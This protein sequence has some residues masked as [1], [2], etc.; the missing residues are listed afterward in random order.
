MKW[1]AR[2][3]NHRG[4]LKLSAGTVL[5]DPAHPATTGGKIRFNH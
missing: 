2:G 3:S 5:A 4:I 1:K